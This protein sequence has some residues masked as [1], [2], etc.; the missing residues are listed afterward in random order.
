MTSSSNYHE[1]VKKAKTSWV[2]LQ[3]TLS[4]IDSFN[5]FNA[6]DSPPLKGI[7][8]FK[9]IFIYQKSKNGTILEQ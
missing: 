7:H 3:C 2:L 1:L 8:S 5:L 4:L 6:S 9:Q